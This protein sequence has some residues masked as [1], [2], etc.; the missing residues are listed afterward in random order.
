MVEVAMRNTARV[1]MVMILGLA[2]VV[3]GICNDVPFVFVFE[4]AN[5]RPT[6]F[7]VHDIAAAHQ[8]TRGEGIQIGILDHYFGTDIHPGLYAGSANF[9]GDTA[10]EKLTTVAEHGYWMAKTLR[11]IAPGVE[12]FALNTAS[13]SQVER[14]DAISRAVDWAIENDLDILTFS[15]R[16]FSSDVR[17]VVDA[18]VERAHAAGIVTVFIHYGHTENLLPGGLSTTLEDGR[19]PDIF[20]LQYDYSVLFTPWYAEIQQS[21][22]SSRGYEPFLSISSTAV[23]TA[24]VV[25][26]ILSLE[27]D[28]TPGQCRQI[29]RQTS[30]S[31]TFE[32]REVPRVLDAAAAVAFVRTE[33]G[34]TSSID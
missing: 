4:N 3:P 13:K 31:M 32:G 17:N 1:G 28:L 33:E 20:V 19:E 26:M 7:S 18:A 8:L 6:Y 22:R 34:M 10:I 27:P 25:A 5:S 9:L 16:K 21:G 2:A 29:L 15:H 24:G 30:R 14:A 12:I 11:E 23:V